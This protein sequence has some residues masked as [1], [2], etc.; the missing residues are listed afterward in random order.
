[1]KEALPS[2]TLENG[3]SIPCLGRL[4][5]P[6]L[7]YVCNILSVYIVIVSFLSNYN[8]KT[9]CAKSLSLPFLGDFSGRPHNYQV[10]FP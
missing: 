4:M 5:W 7:K 3:H 6:F 1:M 8:S 10:T 9:S 2:T